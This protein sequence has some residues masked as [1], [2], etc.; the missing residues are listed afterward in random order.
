MS[1]ADQLLQVYTL[2][3]VN[4]PGAPS[5]T[6]DLSQMEK[7]IVARILQSTS[8]GLTG[9]AAGSLGQQV[10]FIVDQI[11]AATSS[12]PLTGL[13]LGK[14][15]PYTNGSTTDLTIN[16]ADQTVAPVNGVLR[17]RT[18]T[19]L[20]AHA[21]RITRSRCILM[22]DTIVWNAA[23][24][25]ACEASGAP[26]LGAD[27][28]EAFPRGGRA[29]SGS[30]EAIG[31]YGGGFLI[32]LAG[33]VNGST[34]G[35]IRASGTAGNRNTTAGA[36]IF[37]V[38]GEGALSSR[39]HVLQQGPST[40]INLP[41][42][43]GGEASAAGGSPPCGPANLLLGNGGDAAAGAQVG[44]VGGGSG[45]GNASLTYAGGGS[46][47]GGGGSVNSAGGSIAG[48]TGLEPP[49]VITM[50]ELWRMATRGGGGGGAGV[51]TTG[52]NNAA[53]GGG[54]G[55]VGLIVDTETQ[56]STLTASGGAAVGSGAA[57]G[58]G[59]TLRQVV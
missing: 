5:L 20:T 13:G 16:G 2:G 58:A 42:N 29:A 24:V 30:G 43:W 53:G 14:V 41:E 26:G 35:T 48:G 10:Q 40:Q 4:P 12:Q 28:A 52:A 15:F 3:G 21:L 51:N 17:Y 25:I 37:G 55:F 38:G 57:G 6:G 59:A 1:A 19:F 56:V 47:V 31:G 18:I 27:P 44:G 32:V 36:A 39:M 49:D 22:V 33:T 8:P 46:G 45:L 23:G 54:G 9:N 50:I 7:A 34:A 11:Q